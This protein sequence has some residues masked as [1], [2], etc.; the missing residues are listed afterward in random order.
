[1]HDKAGNER[2]SFTVP[3][4]V[5]RHKSIAVLGKRQGSATEL[6]RHIPG[7]SISRVG[8]TNGGLSVCVATVVPVF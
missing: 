3:R 1:M 4:I 6:L 2:D 5:D 8:R 7:I